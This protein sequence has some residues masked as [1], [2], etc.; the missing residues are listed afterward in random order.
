MSKDLDKVIDDLL[1]CKDLTSWF[2]M[3]TMQYYLAGQYNQ[4]IPVDWGRKRF[5]KL[6]E[7]LKKWV[8][9][10]EKVEGKCDDS[11]GV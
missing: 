1:K 6:L 3:V 11:G 7:E 10:V 8:E 9:T 4:S 2:D 5:D